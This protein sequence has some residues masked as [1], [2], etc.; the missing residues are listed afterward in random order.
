MTGTLYGIG[1]GPGDPELMTLK[2]VRLLEDCD[3]AAFPGPIAEE[4]LAYQ[5][6]VQAVPELADK[7]L[8]SFSLPMVLD[9][10]KRYHNQEK[11]AEAIAEYLDA[12][13]D[14]A[15]P[16]LGDV[17]I[18]STFSYVQKIL[19]EMG[20]PTEFVA[21]VTSFSAAAARVGIPLCEWE[22]PL[23]LVPAAH[24]PE[25]KLDQPGT[26]VLMKSGSQMAQVKQLLKHADKEVVMVEN[27]G[28]PEEAVYHSV[29]E[30]PDDAGY[31][32]LIIA[33]EKK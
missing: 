27:C 1:I 13:K 7:E 30:I 25:G 18:Y 19:K 22:E 9:A 28:M 26:Y 10:E 3:V 16:V 8:L 29:E 20:Y 32:S 6:S 2:A 21:G 15:F 5:I 23:H 12:G 11:A 33:K 14:V 31:F 4:T 24:I 17:T